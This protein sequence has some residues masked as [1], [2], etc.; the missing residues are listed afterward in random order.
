MTNLTYIDRFDYSDKSFILRVADTCLTPLRIAL[1]GNHF[2]SQKEHVLDSNIYILAI[3]VFAG[4]AALIIFPLTLISLAV[5]WLNRKEWQN[6]DVEPQPQAAE[7]DENIE[8]PLKN[9]LTCVHHLDK[10]LE[11]PQPGSWRAYGKKQLGEE[12]QTF[13]KFLQI[14]NAEEP[15]NKPLVIQRIGSFDECELKIINITADFLRVFH[16]I[17]IIVADVDMTMAQLKDRK[18]QYLERYNVYDDDDTQGY[19]QQRIQLE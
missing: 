18:L 16:Q 9:E 11:P 8:D 1:N 10:K 4:L 3:R 5:K 14:H 19:Y 7:P 2:N 17:P 12:N 6:K 15:D 13:E